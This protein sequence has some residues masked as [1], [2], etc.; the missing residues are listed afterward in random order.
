[1]SDKK[2]KVT[3]A[4]L[5]KALALCDELMTENLQLK[6]DYYDLKEKARRKDMREMENELMACC[7]DDLWDDLVRNQIIGSDVPPMMVADAIIPKLL[8]SREVIDRLVEHIPA[9]VLAEIEKQIGEF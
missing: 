9:P 6:K 4:V 3:G 1:M 2:L 8:R 5:T 7:M